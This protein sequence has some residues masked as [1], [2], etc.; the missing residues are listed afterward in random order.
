MPKIL[1]DVGP[2]DYL[3]EALN[4]EDGDVLWDEEEDLQES[5]EELGVWIF[6][7]FYPLLELVFICLSHDN[8]WQ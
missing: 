6:N 5:K 4:E 8:T 2:S 7:T 3:N 1:Q